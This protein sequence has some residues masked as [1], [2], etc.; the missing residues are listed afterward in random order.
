MIDSLL[1][2]LADV[3]QKVMLEN[4][5]S[6]PVVLLANKVGGHLGL[7]RGRENKQQHEEYV[8]HPM[9]LPLYAV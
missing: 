7:C 5:G 9:T 4:G 8:Y 1:Q 6:V 2:W 3:N